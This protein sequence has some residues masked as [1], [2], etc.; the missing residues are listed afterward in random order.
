MSLTFRQLAAHIAVMDEEQKDSDVTI[1]CTE[2]DEWFQ[3]T[4]YDITEETDVMD[5]N[6][7]FVTIQA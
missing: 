2:M 4:G 1:H 7:P 6:H 3:A 5:K